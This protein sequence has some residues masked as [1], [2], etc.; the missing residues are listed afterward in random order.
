MARTDWQALFDA[1]DVAGWKRR[2]CLP[3]GSRSETNHHPGHTW[4]VSRTPERASCAASRWPVHR[5]IRYQCHFVRAR[6]KFSYSNFR[7]FVNTFTRERVLIGEQRR[8]GA[9]HG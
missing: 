7:S 2:P 1:V 3:G 8:G 4:G 5:V 9:A 6:E